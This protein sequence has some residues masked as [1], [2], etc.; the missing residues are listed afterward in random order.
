MALSLAQDWKGVDEL[1]TS[2]VRYMC[3]R[4]GCTLQ[5]SIVVFLFL[6]PNMFSVLL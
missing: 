4:H 2:K 3:L 5:G 6:F 1:V